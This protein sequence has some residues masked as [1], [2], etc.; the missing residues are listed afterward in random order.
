MRRCGPPSSA[1][2][3][4]DTTATCRARADSSPS[5][6]TSSARTS[7]CSAS[8]RRP[9]RSEAA[10]WPASSS[11]LQELLTAASKHRVSLVFENGGTFSR[12]EQVAEVLRECPS[13]WLGASY[14]IA[15][16]AR[17]GDHVEAALDLLGDRL[18][19][20][21]LK[22]LQGN[23]PVE[24]GHGE[25]PLERG[26]SH[27]VRTEYT[28]WLVVEWM[29]CWR[30]ELAEADGVLRRALKTVESWILAARES[31]VPRTSVH[32]PATAAASA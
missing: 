6:T 20:V 23:Q 13:P 29:R 5:P 30:P 22:D 19:S 10:P 7:A 15:V 18:I 12:A 2:H 8:T 31:H 26:V 14:N 27:L 24:I 16:G 11:R 4:R 25:I 9:A 1:A 3:S 17:D 21:K 28:G 32:S